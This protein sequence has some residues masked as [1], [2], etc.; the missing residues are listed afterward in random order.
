MR[1]RAEC[2]KL[3]LK[4]SGVSAVI[5]T[6]GSRRLETTDESYYIAPGAHVIGSVRLE[7]P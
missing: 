2:A 1:R 5:Y 6:I 7:P 3:G 4:L